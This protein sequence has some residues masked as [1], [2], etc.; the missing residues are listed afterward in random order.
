MAAKTATRLRWFPKR[1]T[2]KTEAVMRRNM[3]AAAVTLRDDVK[4]KLN[5]GQPTRTTAGGNIIGLDPSKPGEP[6]K[7]V[8][9]VY[10]NSIR[11]DVVRTSTEIVGLVG[12]DQKRAPALEFGSS[13]V[14]ARP[15]FRPA[16]REGQAKLRAILGRRGV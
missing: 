3:E 4:I 15:H 8:T 11:H 14:G 9:S 12:T 10:Q 16:L 5:R 1:V 7:K 6:P 2:D 13:R